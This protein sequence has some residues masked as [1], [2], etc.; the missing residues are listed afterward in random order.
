MCGGT[1]EYSR[2]GEKFG[3]VLVW[4]M[5]VKEW[6]DSDE[7]RGIDRGQKIKDFFLYPESLKICFFISFF[8]SQ[9][10]FWFVI[11]LSCFF[12]F[13]II[14]FCFYLYFY[15]LFWHFWVNS[16]SFILNLLQIS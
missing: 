1:E 8:Y 9:I 11:T 3:L 4:W 15:T 2:N 5:H 13:Y 7:S 6:Q 14:N 12:V 10:S 16:N